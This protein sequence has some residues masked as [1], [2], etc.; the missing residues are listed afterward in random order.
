[1]ET[2]KDFYEI[3]G[4]NK[5]ATNTEIK[6][7]YRKLAKTNHPDK[8]GS[9]E[10]FARIA[11]AYEVLSDSVRRAKYDAGEP[12]ETEDRRTTAIRNLSKI[13]NSVV[14]GGYFASGSS[15]LI[16]IIR[17]EINQARLKMEGDIEELE[18]EIKTL[19]DTVKR[20]KGAEFLQKSLET[21][22]A[23]KETEID[24]IKEEIETTH[25]M[26]R[27]LEGAEYERDKESDFFDEK[28]DSVG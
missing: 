13:L 6:A 18:I 20:I 2:S 27:L 25:E 4:L 22:I 19:Q 1:M 17:A 28:T 5:D 12:I 7:A 24:T 9:G 8:G 26:D 16:R 21:K 23:F 11:R 14:S 3:L 15:D 10:E